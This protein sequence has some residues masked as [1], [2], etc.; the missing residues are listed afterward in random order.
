M[1]NLFSIALIT[2]INAG[3][4]IDTRTFVASSVAIGALSIQVWSGHVDKVEVGW[5][6]AHLFAVESFHINGE[7]WFS[8]T[9]TSTRLIFIT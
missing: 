3:L 2:D 9:A 8:C 4:V 5:S 6:S 1:Q 7:H